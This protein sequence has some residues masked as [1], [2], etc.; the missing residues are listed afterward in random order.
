MAVAMEA[1]RGMR[2]RLLVMGRGNESGVTVW[3][4]DCEAIISLGYLVEG[5]LQYSPL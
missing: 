4:T 5:D 3:A 2:G 1:N